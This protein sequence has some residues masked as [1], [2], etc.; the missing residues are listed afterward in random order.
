MSLIILAKETSWAESTTGAVGPEMIGP[1]S[2]EAITSLEFEIPLTAPE[3]LPSLLGRKDPKGIYFSVVIARWSG[4]KNP[5]LRLICGQLY[6]ACLRSFAMAVD[7][8]N[9]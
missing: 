9:L 5:I 6:P 8:G 3:M 7:I 2:E 4:I 1:L